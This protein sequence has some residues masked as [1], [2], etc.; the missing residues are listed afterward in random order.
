MHLVDDEHLVF[1]HLRRYARLLHQCL[2]VLHGVVAR[3]VE[4]EYVERA[5]LVEGA[6]AFA[7]VAGFAA[8]CRVETVDCFGEY[9]RAGGLAYA[10]RPAEEVGVGQLA[11]F[12]RVL[13]GRGN[14][15]LPHD[16]RE[17][18]GRYLRALTI[19]SLMAEQR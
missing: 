2:Y 5:L 8:L 19:K 12:D 3:C 15:L 9:A 16:R 17:V 4:F 7:F 6:A 10:A 1:A 11:A 13:Q 14:V 18:A